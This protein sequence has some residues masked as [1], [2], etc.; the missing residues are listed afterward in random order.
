MAAETSVAAGKGVQ[1]LGANTSVF[2][3]MRG[4]KVF[5]EDTAMDFKMFTKR[6]L[7]EILDVIQQAVA[8]RAESDIRS[9]VVR[10]KNLVNGEYCVCGIGR[11]GADGLAEV[12]RV[13]NIDYP[14]EWLRIYGGSQLYFKDP[15]I[16]NNFQN[17]GPQIW[18]ETYELFGENV[19]EDFVRQAQDFGLYHGVSGGLYDQRTG[20]STIFTFSGRENVFLNH[21]KKIMEFLTPHLHQALVRIYREGSSSCDSLSKREREVIKWI[22][23]GKTNW[24]I[25]M[26]LN[27]SER[28]VKFHVQN[29]EKKLNA[30]N[31]AHA[32][33]IALDQDL[34]S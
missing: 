12:P 10:I 31:K 22:K 8:C 25:S 23:E 28:T 33:A 18:D 21:Q 7:G 5:P 15:I 17:P 6:E 19:S 14:E 11:G 1:D 16:L 13:I 32:I 9:L 27:I 2:S 3:G 29:I 34:V 30:V 20:L 26:I 4:E 24:E